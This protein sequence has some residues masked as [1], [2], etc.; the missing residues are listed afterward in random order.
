M[1]SI[2]K[3]QG[4][5]VEADQKRLEDLLGQVKYHKDIE[6]KGLDMVKI[7]FIPTLIAGGIMIGDARGKLGW[8]EPELAKLRQTVDYK[9][10]LNRIVGVAFHN[11]SDMHSMLDSA[12]TALT[13]MSTQWEDLDSHYSGVLGHIDKADQKA[14]QNKYK[15]LT[16]SLNAAKNSWK[17][18]KTDVVTLQEGIKIAEKKEQDFLN[19]LR[20]SNVFYF[21][22]KIHNAYTFEIKTGTNAPNASYKVMNLTKNT[23][24]NMWSGGG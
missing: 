19:Q 12:I 10:T 16:P 15:F 24:H 3:N 21:Y 9:I 4:A 6:S 11:I 18:L 14:D 8:L 1:Q 23:V 22:K 7:P 20:P 13:Y 17:T 2:L 5:D